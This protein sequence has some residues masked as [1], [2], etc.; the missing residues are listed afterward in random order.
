[1]IKV[2]RSADGLL[3]SNSYIV[4]DDET[5]NCLII[6][7]G[8]DF[9]QIYGKIKTLGLNLSG[10]IL[11]HG[12]YDHV[13]GCKDCKG[14]GFKIY[15]SREDAKM[16][17][18]PDNLSSFF[19][20]DG[21]SVEADGILDEGNNKIG[22]INFKVIKTPGHTSGSICIL[23]E[24]LLFSGDT[25]FKSSFGRYDFPTGN[26]QDLKSSI[27]EK[28]FLLDGKTVVLPGHGDITTIESEREMNPINDY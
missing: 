3:G 17:V 26:L 21:F 4:Y 8:G 10:V 23:I 13:A 1:M 5:K 27:K 11:T 18:S 24:N 6:D 7:L 28:L 9:L 20:A 14:K 25:L 16:L 22:G 2:I 12:H 19:G 15:S